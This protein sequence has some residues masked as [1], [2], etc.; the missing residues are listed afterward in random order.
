M[1]AANYDFEIEQGATFQRVIS[2]KDSSG[3]PINLTGYSARMQCRKNRS[4]PTP[5]FTAT[6]QNGKL[7]ISGSQGII[8][9][10]IPAS[11]TDLFDFSSAVYDLEIESSGGIVTRLLEGAVTLSKSVTR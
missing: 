4:A 10:S 7:S 5:I 1:P 11:E 8:T 9:L 3:N 6:T 2:W